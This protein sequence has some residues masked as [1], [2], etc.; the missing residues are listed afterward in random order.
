[1]LE[2]PGAEYE[3]ARSNLVSECFA[4]LSYSERNLEEES[5]EG[6]QMGDERE[7]I[8]KRDCVGLLGWR[9]TK[10]WETIEW[11]DGQVQVSDKTI[12][13]FW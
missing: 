9:G 7:I 6:G 3:V 10:S 11:S 5:G 8:H 1:M 2:L 13:I 4:D 12:V